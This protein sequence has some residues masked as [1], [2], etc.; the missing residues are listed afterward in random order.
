MYLVDINAAFPT[1][2]PARLCKTL[3]KM[4]F[5]PH[6]IRLLD[7]LLSNTSTNFQIGDYQ[8]ESKSLNIRFPQGSL[9]LHLL[10][11]LYNTPLLRK[12]DN[13]LDMIALSFINYVDF[14]KAK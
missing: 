11:I 12:A 8:L 13:I 5:C 3:G 9:L 4:G 1:V 6:T 14:S 10:D 7:D 2:N